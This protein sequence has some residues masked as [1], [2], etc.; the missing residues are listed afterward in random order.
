MSHAAHSIQRVFF[1]LQNHKGFP[2][3]I[4]S[5]GNIEQ[6]GLLESKARIVA[7]MSENCLLYTSDAADD[8]LQV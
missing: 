7:G 8:L 4:I 3:H 2:R 6:A 5:A 1:Q